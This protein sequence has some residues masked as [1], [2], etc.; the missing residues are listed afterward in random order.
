MYITNPTRGAG[1]RAGN[2]TTNSKPE[3]H[4][5]CQPVRVPAHGRQ[6]EEQADPPPKKKEGGGGREN[7]AQPPHRLPTPQEA[8]KPPTQTAPKTGPLKGAPGDDPAKT[9]NIKPRAAAHQKKGHSK[10]A[11]THH[12]GTT[13]KNQRSPEEKGRGDRDHE[14]KDRDN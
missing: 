5:E 6:R 2:A 13:K 10:H 3:S 11:D 12:A 9:G 8:A 7:G 14:T 4:T 1:A